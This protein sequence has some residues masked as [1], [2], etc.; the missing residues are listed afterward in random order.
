METMEPVPLLEED[1]DWL[2]KMA[3]L[4][5]RDVS[6]P[7]PTTARLWSQGYAK[8]KAEDMFSITAKGYKALRDRA[9]GE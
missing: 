8:Q 3:R 2:E 9:G 7:N 4:N 6:P 1:W 5:G